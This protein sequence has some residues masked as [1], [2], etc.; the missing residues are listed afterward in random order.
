MGIFDGMAR[1]LTGADLPTSPPRRQAAGFDVRGLGSTPPFWQVGRP[2]WPERNLDVYRREGYGCNVTVYACV[3]KRA[4]AVSAAT[5][6]VY[7][8]VDGQP[9]ELPEHPVRQ[10]MSA[11][12]PG[13][14]EA[15]FLLLTVLYMDTCGFAAIEK[16]R[17]ANGR[18]VELWHL[19]PDW[20]KPIPRE[21][22]PPDW[23]YRIP[24]RDAVILP[25]DDVLIITGNPG[26]EL[27]YTGVSPIA[28]ALREI[29]VENDATEFLKLFFQYGGAP[30]YAL[31][32]PTQITDQARAD[33]MRERWQ[34]T[35]GGIQNWTSVALLHGG[36]D[37]RQVGTNID[38]MAYPQLR[39]L[40]E[41]KICSAFGVPPI[42]IGAQ[43]GLEK[44]TYSNF[45]EARR[46]FYED[47]IVPLWA[48]LDGALTRDLL[49]EFETDRA[50][51]VGFDT[52]DIAALQE[53]VTP[54]WQ[55]ATA[56][57]TAGAITL[58]Q[59][60]REVGLPGFDAAGEVLY[61][62]LTAQP[63][64]P[65]D[66]VAYVPP[67]TAA[68][69]AAALAAPAV[70]RALPDGFSTRELEAFEQRK[71]VAGNG[72]AQFAR[73]ARRL[74]PEMTRFWRGQGE[75]IAGRVLRADAPYEVRALDDIDWMDELERLASV[76][77]PH[78]ARSGQLAFADVSR[79]VKVG[80]DW[81][82][83]NPN[84]RRVADRLAGRIVG[85]NATTEA[86]VRR[87]VTQALDE[88]LS[89]P[90]LAERLDGLF[91]R[92]YRNRALTVARTESQVAYNS[93]AAAGYRETGLVREIQMF[94]N[95][96]HE[97]DYG[98]SDGLTC[99]Q[100]NGRRVPVEDAE[101]HI[102]AEHPNGS[103]AI[104]AVTISPEEAFG[105]GEE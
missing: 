88:G 66:L 9:E 55:R 8:D 91:A 44:A 68:Q 31:V 56:A 36:L 45:E 26:T 74:A 75:R 53:D 49:V 104:A 81:D 83:T 46:T 39:M 13:M 12:N 57:F 89:N 77:E 41:A 86:D 34:Q 96:D 64:A 16:V 1:Y 2:V 87:V 65:A 43:V 72:R 63:V 48:R 94:D 78:Y 59:F 71:L 42:L 85:I 93:A 28:I 103:L 38:E 67:A 21:E 100:R 69:P 40:T 90:Q 25:M 82:L 76:L 80:V 20:I 60:Q 14:S 98:A 33:A 37:I 52:S 17:S 73:L 30:R 50:V 102:D 54:A 5:L 29:G 35:Y 27:K 47:T 84:V 61:L 51:S 79:Q 7:R 24:G 3:T 4:Q 92:T 97:D 11:P 10:L 23:E 58:N 18:V 32:S 105:G 101:M 15:E 19:R 95:P 6:R 22:G 62:P 70:T 99:A